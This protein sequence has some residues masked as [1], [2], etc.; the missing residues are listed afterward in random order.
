MEN[1]SVLVESLTRILYLRKRAQLKT[2][3]LRVPSRIRLLVL[4][5]SESTNSNYT[6]KYFT[7]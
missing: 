7:V 6:T 2:N 1:N 3:M 4:L 5:S